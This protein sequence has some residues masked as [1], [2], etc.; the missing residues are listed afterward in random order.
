MEIPETGGTLVD[1]VPSVVQN[2]KF[3]TPELLSQHRP[4]I[5]IV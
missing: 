2:P 1:I 5:G 3:Q 4:Y